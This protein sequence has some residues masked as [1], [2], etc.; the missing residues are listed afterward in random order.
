MIRMPV[1]CGALPEFPPSHGEAA[2]PSG[3]SRTDDLYRNNMPSGTFLHCGDDAPG[4][5]SEES[6]A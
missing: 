6:H 1:D 5:G 3:T 2:E 4:C